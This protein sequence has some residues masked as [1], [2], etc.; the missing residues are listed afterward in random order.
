MFAV[1]VDEAPTAYSGNLPY[2]GVTCTGD[3][4]RMTVPQGSTPTQTP[5]PTPT[6]SATPTPQ[7]TVSPTQNKITVRYLQTTQ[8]PS[9]KQQ[10]HPN[11]L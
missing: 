5:T 11:Q 7:P 9:M 3:Y 2:Y 1:D 4:C 10:N 6:P 8:M